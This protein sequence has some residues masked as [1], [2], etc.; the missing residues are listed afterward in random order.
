MPVTRKVLN[1]EEL[2][3]LFSHV[4]SNPHGIDTN[5]VA[6]RLGVNVATVTR[7]GRAYRGLVRIEEEIKSGTFVGRFN[8]AV[9]EHAA[10][11]DALADRMADAEANPASPAL[12]ALDLAIRSIRNAQQAVD[13]ATAAIQGETPIDAETQAR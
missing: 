6:D 10:D 4:D 5:W 2:K 12:Q 11:K 8:R 13:V 3:W 7:Y 1:V 9:R